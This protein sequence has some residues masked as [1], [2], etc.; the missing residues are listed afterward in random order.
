MGDGELQHATGERHGHW[1][2]AFRCPVCGACGTLGI[3]K[4]AV[5]LQCPEGPPKDCAPQF[6]RLYCG[7]RFV[8][9][10]PLGKLPARLSC[11]NERRARFLLN[12]D[13]AHHRPL[14]W[15]RS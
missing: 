4:E 11:V 12:A 5:Q 1:I 14:D 10:P 3:P 6:Q 8:Q 9:A 15:V 2:Y 7:A 13:S